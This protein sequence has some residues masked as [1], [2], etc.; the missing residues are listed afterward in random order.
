MDT[1]N[2][3]EALKAAKAKAEHYC[4]SREC[5]R[6]D[7]ER[8]FSQWEV[9]EKIWEDV[10]SHLESYGFLDEKRYI[11]AFIDA[12]FKH[13]NWG[14]I[15]IKHA[16]KQKQLPEDEIE[17]LLDELDHEEYLNVL[18]KLV[19]KKAFQV[20]GS[21]NYQKRQKV[22]NSLTSKGFEPSLIIEVLN[23]ENIFKI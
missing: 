17:V 18:R 5:C 12:K 4:A 14:K 6:F 10:L 3:E 19:N 9:S 21:N 1:D 7:L 16:L 8:K 23:E 13:N 22:I 20:K 15:K 2:R 11:R